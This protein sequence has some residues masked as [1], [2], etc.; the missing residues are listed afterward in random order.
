MTNTLGET[1]RRLRIQQRMSQQE[2]AECA[3]VHRSTVRLTEQGKTTPKSET[4]QRLAE[5]LASSPNGTVDTV[6]A[7][8]FTRE[9]LVAAGLLQDGVPVEPQTSRRQRR[10]SREEINEL[11]FS[12]FGNRDYA[13]GL[14]DMFYHVDDMS[15][16]QKDVLVSMARVLLRLREDQDRKRP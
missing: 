13:W 6:K 16:E 7:A 5:G 15:D 11:L 1:L 9:L 2:L 12:V 3:E 10:W 8:A 14:S 4:L